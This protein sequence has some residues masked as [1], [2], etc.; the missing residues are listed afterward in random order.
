MNLGDIKLPRLE[1]ILKLAAIA[2]WL[3]VGFGRGIWLLLDS[4]SA[5]NACPHLLAGF[6][7]GLAFWCTGVILPDLWAL[8]KLPP[9]KT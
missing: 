8:F 7:F 4:Q 2:I 9:P 3:F 6:L 5:A 1:T